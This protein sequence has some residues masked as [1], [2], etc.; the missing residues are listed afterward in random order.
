[1]LRALPSR[2]SSKKPLCLRKDR[3]FLNFLFYLSRQKDRRSFA[4]FAFRLLPRVRHVA[5]VQQQP[6][7]N[8]HERKKTMSNDLISPVDAANDITPDWMR[9]IH[10]YDAL[11]IQ[12]FVIVGNDSM[13][14]PIVEPCE[15]QDAMLWTVH[16]HY[17]NGGVN[18]FGDF[19]TEAEARAFHD[20]L[21]SLFPHLGGQDGAA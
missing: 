14:N 1:L 20:Q 18:D 3:C 9:N 6:H 7:P 13:D 15:P 2:A 21:L 4:F 16:G 5:G 19:P 12:P 10:D 11:E 17:R 8:N